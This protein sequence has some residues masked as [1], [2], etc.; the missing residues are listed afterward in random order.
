MPIRY[1]LFPFLS[2]I[3]TSLTLAATRL[4]GRGAE[5]AARAIGIHDLALFRVVIY[6][7]WASIIAWALAC[8]LRQEGVRAADLG[9]RGRLS[10]E[11]IGLAVLAAWLA[12][13]IW[14]PL[15][16]LRQA[17]GLP[18]Y[19]DPRQRGFVQPTTPWEFAL[20]ILAGL[21][22]V[23]P[24]EETMFR[25]YVLPA[26]ET[27]AGRIGALM[28]HNLLFALYHGAIGPGL[29][30]YMFFWSFFP[31]LLYLRYRSIY[32]PMLMHFLNNIWVDIAVPMLFGH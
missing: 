9:W 16:A 3:A 25:G 7:L 15:D 23:P 6:A 22:L 17:I 13:M 8:L 11:A 27:R 29:V 21:I 10:P 32:P 18:L 2:V 19:W 31:A 20:V 5:Q 30:L 14:L 4:L 12:A 28:L 1:V 26:L 24:A